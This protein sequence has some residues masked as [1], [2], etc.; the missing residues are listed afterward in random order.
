MFVVLLQGILLGIVVSI[1]AGPSFFALVQIG[2]QRGFKYGLSMSVG[3][4]LSD[5]TLIIVS[6]YGLA[7]YISTDENTG[8]IGTV[9]G[10]ILIL[11]GAYSVLTAKK[12]TTKTITDEENF[13][14]EENEYLKPIPKRES[15]RKKEKKPTK[16]NKFFSSDA[17]IL[18]YFLKGYFINILNPVVLIL[19]AG[20]VV[21]VTSMS[22]GN[23]LEQN[24]LVFFAGSI[25][26]LFVFNILKVLLGKQIKNFLKPRIIELINIIVG[27][28]FVICGFVLIIRVLFFM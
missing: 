3:I 4:T 12:K 22:N 16:F 15:K 20:A 28:I 24:V 8:I 26:M 11:F 18:T 13:S 19:W 7:T 23:S 21:T 5:L 2:I 10:I 25:A 17:G 9:G 6:Y 1:S 27:I 14:S